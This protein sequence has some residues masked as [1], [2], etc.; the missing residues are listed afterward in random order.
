MAYTLISMLGTGSKTEKNKDGYQITDYSFPNGQHFITRLFMQAVF[1]SRKDINQIILLGTDTSSWD[2]LV[3]AVNDTRDETVL[4]WNDLFDQCESLVK[5]KEPLGVTKENLDRLE[6]YLTERFGIEVIIEDHTHKVDDSTSEELF[7][8]YTGITK[9]V[10]SNNNILFDITHG[11][12]SMPVLL[13]QSLQYSLSKASNR[14]VEIIYGELDQSKN[15]KDKAIKYGYARSLSSYWNYSELSNALDVFESKLDGFR[16]ADLIEKDWK[17][18]SVAICRFSEIVLTNF[19]LHIFEIATQ[20]KT[21]ISSYPANAQKWHS[22]I[23]T[24]FEEVSSFIDAND[25]PRT[26]YKYSN[27]LYEKHLIVQAIIT[28]QIAVEA[29][30]AKYLKVEHKLGDYKWWNKEG[31]AVLYEL[32]D[33]KNFKQDLDKLNDFRNQVAHGG[34]KDKN[35]GF[36]TDIK[37]ISERYSEV[38]RHGKRGVEN[39]FK[40]LGL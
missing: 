4:L 32:K 14:D 8:C 25:K 9:R 15:D 30:I 39:L 37:K 20:M 12:R 36:K 19:A 31:S 5:G 21:A 10:K 35:G 3:D 18:G 11:F 6:K 16:L 26:L 28:L 33:E 13:Y 17:L 29:A 23:R 22:R 34:G 40:E 24:M 38:Y 1:Q 2:Y 27:F 7:N